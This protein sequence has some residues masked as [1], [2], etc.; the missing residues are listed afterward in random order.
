MGLCRSALGR[1]GTQLSEEPE[2]LQPRTLL[3]RSV[4]TECRRNTQAGKIG[5]TY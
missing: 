3:K 2:R 4:F 1:M 5:Q